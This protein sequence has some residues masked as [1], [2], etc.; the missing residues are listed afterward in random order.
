MTGPKVAWENEYS[1]RTFL[2]DAASPQKDVLRALKELAR[3]HGL[4][5][6]GAQV[7]D[8]GCGT[9]RN[10][11][12]CARSGASVS[13]FDIAENAVTIAR[14]RAEEE[15]LRIAFSVHD[16]AH[17]MPYDADSFDLV[18]DITSS[19][20][21]KAS[22]RSHFLA[23]CL[24]VLKPGGILLMK[25]LCLTGDHNARALI[26]ASSVGEA[27]MYELPGTTIIEKAW[28]VDEVKSYY[29][30]V[31]EPVTFTLKDSYMRMN[32][33]SYKRRFIIAAWRKPF[34]GGLP[35]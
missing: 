14:K 16:M 34:D 7:L 20:S 9:G 29:G 12:H 27:G 18:L 28:E 6:D 26:A 25:A 1:E 10:S 17:D 32:G 3:K 2:T 35:S 23:E 30:A 4:F 19:N 21:L 13:A 22:E 11:L 24:R 8:A 31:F 15:G 33:R 5:L